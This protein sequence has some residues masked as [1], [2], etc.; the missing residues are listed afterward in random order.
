MRVLVVSDIHA[1]LTALQAVLEDAGPVDALWSLGD[2]VGYGPDPNACIA[3][4]LEFEHLAIPGNH[5]WG[6][7][8]RLDLD[9][10]NS[11]ARAAN[12]WTRTQLSEEGRRYL[13]DLPDLL[14]TGQITLA[15]GSPRYPIWEYLFYASTAALNFP[16]LDTRV[17]L[18]GH[19]HMP[20][21][22][23]QESDDSPTQVLPLPEGE[24]LALDRGRYIVNPG[25]VGQPRDGDPRAA[26]MIL[27]PEAL[28]VEHRRVAYPI[29]HT[30]ERMRSF[31]LPSRLISRLEVGW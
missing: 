26:Y 16:H 19:T 21:V 28:I 8:G 17:C 13:E 27:D 25:S 1:N 24:P 30:Q 22:F 12:L 20:L 9:D 5:D 18:V 15:H 4:I 2:V 10:F 3:A 23:Y 14:V 29:A 7:L 31:G 11:D 6:T